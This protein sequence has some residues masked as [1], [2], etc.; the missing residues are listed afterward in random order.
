MDHLCVLL[1]CQGATGNRFANATPNLV[2]ARLPREVGIMLHR[3]ADDLSAMLDLT[4]DDFRALLYCEGAIGSRFPNVPLLLV[5]A[6]HL[7]QLGKIFLQVA[8][9]LS[10]M[11][12]STMGHFCAEPNQAGS[13]GLHDERAVGV[14]SQNS[15]S[16]A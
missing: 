5:E 14:Q 8:D 3:V 13:S 12:V 15:S 2:E 9:E 7:E 6:T 4:M 11:R 16:L 1:D 10:A